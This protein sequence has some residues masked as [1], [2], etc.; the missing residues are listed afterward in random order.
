MVII[1]S[2]RQLLCSAMMLLGL[3]LLPLVHGRDLPEI[4]Q[5]GA[6]RHLGI[7][8]ANFVTGSG[9]GLD[10]ELMQLFAARLGV[11]YEFV[12]TNWDKALSD[13]IGRKLYRS[14]T[15]VELREEVPV[16]GDILATGL[17]ILPWR[18]NIVDYSLPTFPTA[19]WLVARADS[20]LQ[21][22]QPSGDIAKDIAAVRSLLSG[23]TV[24]SLKNTCLDPELYHFNDTGA[25]IIVL[26]NR[27]LNEMVPAILN[28][29]AEATLLDVAD[30]LIA[31]EKWPGDI[32]VIGP[33]SPLQQMAVGFSKDSPRL[34]AAFN[35]FLKDISADGTYLK[36]V[37]KYYPSIL[38]YYK[39]YFFN[40]QNRLHD[41]E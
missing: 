4:Q 2:R 19:V 38:D 16:R 37:L 17:T 8:Y 7:P 12:Q 41:L 20:S 15:T 18:K 5:H 40:Y 25:N 6:L 39:D 29:D 10:V 26:E 32:K 30:A 31:L 3:A 11:K 1:G 28:T 21:P 34:R 23:R 9:D 13:L 36:L 27:N 24:L 33:I 22:I 35:E 14:Q